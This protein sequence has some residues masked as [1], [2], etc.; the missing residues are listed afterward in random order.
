MNWIGW[1]VVIIIVLIGYAIISAVWDDVK[2]DREI[3]DEFRH[4]PD[5][6]VKQDEQP[7]SGHRDP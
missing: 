6:E 4:P 5:S 3:W 7:R 2:Y 1:A